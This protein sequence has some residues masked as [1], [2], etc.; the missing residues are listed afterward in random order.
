M[1]VNALKS[2][3]K[4]IQKSHLSGAT[5][6]D[7]AALI[8]DQRFAPRSTIV[9]EGEKTPAALY[10]I[11]EGQV[12]VKSINGKINN[13]IEEGGYFGEDMLQAD[14][15]G[16]NAT[17]DVVAQYTITVMGEEAVLGVLTLENCRKLMDTT[18]LGQGKRT[19]FTSIIDTAIPLKALKKHSILG[20]GTFGQVWLVSKDD[21]PYALK[22]QSKYELLQNGQ[23]QGVIQEKNIMSQLN[24]PFLIR[25]VQTYQDISYLYMLLELV[26]GGEL[27]N[28]MHQESYDGISE[29]DAKFYSVCILEGLSYMHRRQYLYRDLKPENVLIDNQGYPVIVDLGFGKS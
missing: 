11:R 15:N 6:A 1:L 21:R 4:L 28:L 2:A 20:A 19:A 13:V 18:M 5:L 24:H 14:L 17:T 29:S 23:A 25:L 8:E 22:I 12:Q 9:R 26:Q 16:M 10:F 7:L 3:I 27:F